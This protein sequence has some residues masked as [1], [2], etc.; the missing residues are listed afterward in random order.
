MNSIRGILK[1]S[2]MLF[3]AILLASSNLFAASSYSGLFP[4][5]SSTTGNPCDSIF[6]RPDT[7]EFCAYPEAL[8]F[9]YEDSSLNETGF[10]SFLH[11]STSGCDSITVVHLTVTPNPHSHSTG[12]QETTWVTLC[13]YE[14]P[15][16][17]QDSA[18][19]VPGLYRFITQSSEGCDSAYYIQLVVK[20]A[21]TVHIVSDGY[22]CAGGTTTLSISEITRYEYHWSTGSDSTTTTISESGV[23]Y[24][25]VTNAYQCT[26]VDSIIITAVPVPDAQIIGDSV[27]CYGE[28]TNLDLSGDF[29][30]VWDNDSLTTPFTV[31]PLSDTAFFV[32][33][34]DTLTSCSKR[35][36]IHIHVNPTPSASIT[37]SPLEICEGDSVLLTANGGTRYLWSTGDTA[38]SIYA[39]VS[40]RYQVMVFNEFGCY[41][42]TSVMFTVN[43]LPDIT[44]S[45]RTTFCSDESTSITLSGAST[46]LWSTGNTTPTLSTSTPGTYR[47]T[48]TDNHG[49][50]TKLSIPLSYSI[51]QATLTGSTSYCQGSHT[52]LRVVGDSTNTYQWINGNQTDSMVVSSIGQVSVIVTNNI[53]CQLWLNATIT[54]LPIPDPSITVTQGALTIC[55]GSSVSLRAS[56]GLRYAWSNGST[57]NSIIVREEGTYTVTVTASN[58]CSSETSETI[59]VNPTPEITLVTSDTICAGDFVTIHA[60]APTGRSFSWSSGQSTPSITVQPEQGVSYYMVSV[61]DNNNCSS[62]A[63]TTITTIAKPTVYINGLNNSTITIC[64]NT[65]TA[66]AATTG[67]RYQWSNGLTYHTIYVTNAGTYSVTVFNQ[68]G[69]SSSASI[70]VATNPLPVAS[71]TENTAICQGQTAV[72]SATYNNS[73]TY[74]W[75]NGSNVSSI[76]TGTPGTYTVTVTNSSNCSNVLSTSLTVY[77]KPQ[78]TI[79]GNTSICAG[80]TT[81][82]TA[83]ANMPSSYVWSTGDT[84]SVT[85]VNSSNTY[86]VTAYNANGCS[87]SASRTV[88]VHSLPTPYIMGSTTICRG[89]STTLTATGGT[90]YMWSNGHTSAQ[91][92]VSPS[93]NLTYTVTATDQFGCRA[94]VSATVTVNV[95]PSVNILGNRSFCEG[96]STTLTATGGSYYTWSTGENTNA[97][98]VNAIGTYSVTATNSLGCQNSE[99]VLVTSMNLPSISISGKSSICQGSSDTLTA[100]GASQYVWNTGETSSTIHV[101]PTTATTYTVTGYG[102]NGCMSTASKVVNIE[103]KPTV[104]ISGITTICDGE[105]TTLTA[106]GGNTYL[107]ANGNTSD[108]I[109]VSQNGTYAVIATN[110]AG[111]SNSASIAVTVNPTP[112]ITLTGAT[113]FCENS[114]STIMA[115][116]GSSYHWSDGSNQST[117]TLTTGGSYSVTAYNTYGCHSDTTFTAFTLPIP[118]A[119]ISGSTDLCEGES[120]SLSVSENAN[121]S[122]SNGSSTQTINIT[123][124]ESTTYFVTVTNEEGCSNYA[125]KTVNVHPIYNNHFSAEICQGNSYNHYGFDIPVQ[126]EAGTFVFTDSLQSIYGCDSISSLTLTVKPLPIINDG[127]IGNNLVS[128]Y[129]NY[130]YHIQGVENANIFEWSISNPRWTLSNSNINSVFLNIQSPGTGTL[131]VKAINS[132]GYCD[133]GLVISC[134]VSVDEYTNETHILVYPNPVAQTL[135]INM[136]NATVQLQAIEFVDQR[137]RCVY[138]SNTSELQHQIDCTPFANGTYVLRM[139][140][141]DGKVIDHRKII[142]NK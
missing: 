66:L 44:I 35:D 128:N 92:S 140:D 133:T 70:N 11:V 18:L 102:Y 12:Q 130:Y 63:S 64:Q 47:V 37:G 43:P 23:Y 89:Q 76:T 5:D 10:Y 108:H 116:G 36:S 57:T 17:V 109:Q 51:V 54:E 120:G 42:T 65:M 107:W 126:N 111:C 24:V 77:E 68:E 127:I 94:N 55:E 83:S 80:E 113:T 72:L 28:S 106:I 32:T 31:T 112:R 74:T 49:C 15:Y 131:I 52:V 4:T 13:S 58:G 20:D 84:N 62:T 103:S 136:E 38:Q 141:V 53:G 22:L 14:L 29:A 45:G 105:S 121:Y 93:S 125:Y 87:N 123:P 40:G 132:C 6:I 124:Y 97:I 78:V 82:L 56:G 60:I 59:I 61:V 27:L 1:N 129:G 67:A 81:Q 86:R 142:I 122:W 118:D 85:T 101:M 46:Y 69:C 95:I 25:S 16:I 71:I 73:Y 39:K 134:N 137:G 90:S 139:I 79:S 88:V 100:G 9:V 119:S 104:E 98:S 26:T 75:S 114:S 48:C 41:D 34:T 50:V 33:I 115:N 138:R 91:I 117:L 21:P 96:S 110:A 30:Y 7:L 99:S 2:L 3:A 8:P 135:H 19:T